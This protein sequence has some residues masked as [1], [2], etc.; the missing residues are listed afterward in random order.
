MPNDRW[1]VKLLTSDQERLGQDRLTSACIVFDLRT[2]SQN[3]CYIDQAETM[4][5]ELVQA[6]GNKTFFHA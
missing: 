2:A 6:G 1:T 5:M 3:M 4:C